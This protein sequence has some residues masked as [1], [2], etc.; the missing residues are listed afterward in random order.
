[1]GLKSI[2]S[3]TSKITHK[4]YFLNKILIHKTYNFNCSMFKVYAKVKTPLLYSEQLRHFADYT[5]SIFDTLH[6]NYP[7]LLCS[8]YHYSE[9][10]MLHDGMNVSKG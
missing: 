1:M 8:I 5:Q 3:K 6:S 4:M 2:V 7:C 10:E 9:E